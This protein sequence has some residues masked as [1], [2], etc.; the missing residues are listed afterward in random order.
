M[1]D[2]YD[3]EENPIVPMDGD[4]NQVQVDAKTNVSEIADFFDVEIEENADF[5]TVGGLVSFE[6][7]RVGAVGDE[8]TVAGLRFTVLEANEKCILKLQIVRVIEETVSD[9]DNH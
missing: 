8:V 7:G 5:D 2:E 4:G 1:K 9:E 3:F 6:L